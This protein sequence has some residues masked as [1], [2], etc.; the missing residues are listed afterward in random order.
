M[1]SKLLPPSN[2]S[3]ERRLDHLAVGAKPDIIS[4]DY[5]GMHALPQSV[6][7]GVKTF[8]FFIGYARSGSSIVASFM[9]AHPHAVVSH[10]VG[11]LDHASII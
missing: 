4:N 9:D 1:D 7:D 5:N 11:V 3:E 10:E 8:V 6:I 2:D